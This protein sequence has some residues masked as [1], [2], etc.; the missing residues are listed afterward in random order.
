M[1]TLIKLRMKKYTSTFLFLSFIIII[2]ILLHV[3][4]ISYVL[5]YREYH[6]T[7]KNNV[8]KYNYSLFGENNYTKINFKKSFIISNGDNEYSKY[9]KIK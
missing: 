6:S 3:N 1:K 2:S 7:I 5:Y 4:Y 8:T 9:I